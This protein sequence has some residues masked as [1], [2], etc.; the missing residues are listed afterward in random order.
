MRIQEGFVYHIKDEYFKLA[1]NFVVKHKKHN[2]HSF[3]SYCCHV[4]S[5]E[6]ILWMIPMSTNSKK[7]MDVYAT[8]LRRYGKC[9]SIALGTFDNK[10]VAFQMQDLFPITSDYISH[11]HV[12]NGR[13]VLV[14]TNLKEKIRCLFDEIM[15]LRNKRIRCTFTDL[16]AL[17]LLLKKS[18]KC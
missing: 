13:S 14:N 7:Y 10:A 12:R 3:P 8:E 5:A 17:L 2:G 6:D 18:V 15:R 9:L 1:S 4:D 16:D 11:E